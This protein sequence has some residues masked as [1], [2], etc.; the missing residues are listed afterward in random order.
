[1]GDEHVLARLIQQGL[2]NGVGTHADGLPQAEDFLGG[3]IYG[4]FLKLR[5]PKM[6]DS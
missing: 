5:Y 1:M 6:D 3:V 2:C 4:G